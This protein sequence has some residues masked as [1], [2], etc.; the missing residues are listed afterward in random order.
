MALNPENGVT[1]IGAGPAA[2]ADGR[3]TAPT[4]ATM[5]ATTSGTATIRRA[6]EFCLGLL[7]MTPPS[8]CSPPTV[9]NVRVLVL[10]NQPT[11]RAGSPHVPV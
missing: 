4:L 6:P 11:R 7:V 3:R 2:V 10:K 8:C 1:A 9:T 5:A